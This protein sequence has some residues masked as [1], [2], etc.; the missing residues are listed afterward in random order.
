MN[1][2]APGR[3]LYLTPLSHSSRKVRIVLQGG[4]HARPDVAYVTNER[5]RVAGSAAPYF[6][7]APD[8]AIEVVSPSERL[9]EVLGKVSDYLA[10]GSRLVWVV[11]PV[12]E[13]VRVA[14]EA[15]VE[16]ATI[17][18][19]LDGASGRATQSAVLGLETLLVD[20]GEHLEMFFD[21]TEE[22]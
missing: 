22:R 6:P 3:V 15:V 13:E 11:D 20:G 1:A 7:G 16:N 19:L 10:A 4:L 12:R 14:S 17:E 8:L 2:G 21:K 5:E 9:S 18:E